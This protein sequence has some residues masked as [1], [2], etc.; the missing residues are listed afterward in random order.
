MSPPFYGI[1]GPLPQS[2]FHGFPPMGAAP[3]QSLEAEIRDRLDQ[4]QLPGRVAGVELEETTIRLILEVDPGLGAA[5]ETL[6]QSA[7]TALRELGDGRSATVIITA[8]RGSGNPK[9]PPPPAIPGIKHIIAVASGKGGVGKSTTAVNLALALSANRFR[10]GLLDADIYGPSLPKLLKVSGPPDIVDGN[11]IVPH[12]IHDLAVMSMGF[13]IPEEKAT[14]WRGAMVHGALQQ[15]LRQVA[16]DHGGALDV[17]V[18]DLPPGTG[19]AHLTLAQQAPLAGAVIVSTPQD[20]ALIDARKALAMFQRLDVPILGIIENMSYYCCPN[21]NH[22]ADIFGHGG[23]AA[24]AKRL[25]IPFL[26][27][28]P[29]DI[30]IRETSDA[31]FPIV[32]DEP[33]GV[34]ARTY[35]AIARGLMEQLEH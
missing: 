11:R 5:A 20:I 18:V 12:R 35:Q 26:A 19:D 21:C 9:R 3:T 7:E 28:I 29:L 2:L 16:W 25:E 4:M 34:H 10:A 31:G 22:R 27:E 33:D 14:I 23:A 1:K 15:L 6:R 32:L 24:E 13:L 8:Q 30:R 17:L